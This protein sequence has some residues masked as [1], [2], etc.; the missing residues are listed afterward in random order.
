MKKIV[1]LIVLISL[2][3]VSVFCQEGTSFRKLLNINVKISGYGSVNSFS[4]TYAVGSYEQ[5]RTWTP[6]LGFTKISEPEFFSM[7]GYDR[8]S[9]QAEKYAKNSAYLTWGGLGVAVLGLLMGFAIE[10]AIGEDPSDGEMLLNIVSAWGPI[11]GG[12]ISFS[13]GISRGNWAT[14][15]QAQYVAD[16]YNAKIKSAE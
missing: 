16:E 3:S 7:G 6:Y 4:D 9:Q 10:N 8:E 11:L 13:V 15:G 1:S 12:G 14:V 2:V 5:V